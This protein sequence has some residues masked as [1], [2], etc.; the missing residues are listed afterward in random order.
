MSR[1]ES[2]TDPEAAPIRLTPKQIAEQKI[3]AEEYERV[4]FGGRAPRNAQVMSLCRALPSIVE[5]LWERFE[6]ARFLEQ[7]LTDEERAEHAAAEI[8]REFEATAAFANQQAEDAAAKEENKQLTK[9][10]FQKGRDSTTSAK[11]NAEAAGRQR[12]LEKRQDKVD[13]G[14]SVSR[15]ESIRNKPNP[16]RPKPQRA[17]DPKRRAPKK[18]DVRNRMSTPGGDK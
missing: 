10:E 5:R 15:S 9:D 18:G 11:R 12:A 3:V 13:K 14:G 16:R 7:A 6:D 4:A 1:R 2:G 17:G 8:D